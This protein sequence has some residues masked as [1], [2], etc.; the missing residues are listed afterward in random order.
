MLSQ[1]TTPGAAVHRQGQL[2]AAEL[3]EET[4]QRYLRNASSL[5]D[6]DLDFIDKSTREMR[7]EGSS[8]ARNGDPAQ[9]PKSESY[10]D[11]YRY[12]QWQM[13]RDGQYPHC[14]LPLPEG[15]YFCWGP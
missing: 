5:T 2:L 6:D 4:A 14:I 13:K 3:R 7:G 8:D 11:G 12:R 10:M 9:Y 1:M 15:S